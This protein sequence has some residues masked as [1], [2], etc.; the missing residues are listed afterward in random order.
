MTESRGERIVGADEFLHDTRGNVV[1]NT[2]KANLTA[3]ARVSEISLRWTMFQLFFAIHSGAFA[4][5]A[6][7]FTAGTLP[8]F[9]ICIFGLALASLWY[10]ATIRTGRLVEYWNRKMAELEVADEGTVDVFVARVAEE[11]VAVGTPSPA[12]VPIHHLLVRLVHLFLLLWMYLATYS[13]LKIL[14][15]VFSNQR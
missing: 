4:F 11:V 13:T 14:S 1:N 9:G 7:Q 15:V 10:L 12:G 3:Q 8:H 6:T 5:V 2:L